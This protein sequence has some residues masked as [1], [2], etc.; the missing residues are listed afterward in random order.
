MGAGGS[1][2]AADSSPPPDAF[3][4]LLTKDFSA[5]MDRGHVWAVK[6]DNTLLCGGLTA[7]LWTWSSVQGPSSSPITKVAT[8]HMK[9]VWVVTSD[10][11]LYFRK[12]H[13]VAEWN[14]IKF[15]GDCAFVSAGAKS[16][17][18][19]DAEG[20]VYFRTN[21]HVHSPSGEDWKKSAPPTLFVLSI[22]ND[23]A[24]FREKFTKPGDDD[25]DKNVKYLVAV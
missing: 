8:N 21:V 11:K 19:I 2:T 14:E 3:S 12:S 1:T 7:F 6:R 25:E 17:W 15:P 16:V 9:S 20:A 4:S 18:T 10:N 5:G 13:A 24:K 22:V 23:G